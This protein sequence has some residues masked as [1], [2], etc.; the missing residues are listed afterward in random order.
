L[1]PSA[2]CSLYIYSHPI[3]CSLLSPPFSVFTHPL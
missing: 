3:L 2:V 1:Y